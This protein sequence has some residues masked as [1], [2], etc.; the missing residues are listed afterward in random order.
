MEKGML[1]PAHDI[2]TGNAWS[3]RAVHY[4]GGTIGTVRP[5]KLTCIAVMPNFF[6]KN[7]VVLD[8]HHHTTPQPFYS[9]FP[10]QPGEPVS[11]ENFWTLWCKGRLTE[12]DIPTIWLDATP[13]G[14]RTNQCSPPPSPHFL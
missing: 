1:F 9:P 12:A 7:H 8:N 6:I 11:E 3:P 5:D 2:T 4:E 14:F 13:S 10:E